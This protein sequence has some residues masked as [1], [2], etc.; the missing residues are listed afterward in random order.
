MEL[1]IANGTLSK[2]KEELKQRKSYVHP[3]KYEEAIGTLMSLDQKIL[4][5]KEEFT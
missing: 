5:L 3:M 1:E 4:N 2:V